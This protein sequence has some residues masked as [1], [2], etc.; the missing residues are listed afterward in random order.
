MTVAVQR[1]VGILGLD[2]R[3]EL[4][5]SLSAEQVRDERGAQVAGFGRAFQRQCRYGD[6]RHYSDCRRQPMSLLHL[7][8]RM[9]HAARLRY[10]DST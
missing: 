10:A 6:R 5:T 9:I 8:P 1:A 2:A 4:G 3:P 7:S